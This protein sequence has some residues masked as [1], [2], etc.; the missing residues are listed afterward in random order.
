MI[1]AS[2]IDS[3]KAREL[4]RADPLRT[5]RDNFALS[6]D[7]IYLDG[8]S[9]GPLPHAALERMQRAMQRE[10]GDGLIAS[11]N[12][13][14][15]FTK[16]QRVGDRIGRLIGAADGQVV[17][18][19]S[20]SINLFKVLH[21]AFRARPQ[22]SRIV[23]EGGNFPT[24]LY[25]I[26]GICGLT[27]GRRVTL[28][29]EQQ[30]LADVLDEGVAAVVLTQVDFRTGLRH[31]MEAV[32]RRVHEAGA[33]MIWDLAHS[34]GAFPIALDACEV[35]YAV[36]CTYKYLNAGPGGPA[37][38]Y[39]A[40]RLQANAESPLTGWIG[41]ADPFSFSTEYEP[42]P[43]I[44][45]FLC[46]T[47]SILSFVPLEASLDIWESVSLDDVRRKSV[48]LTS[49]F[50]ELVDRFAGDHDLSLASPRDADSRGSQIS[51]RHEHGF[52]IVKA[53][54][55]DGVIG[56]FRAPDILRFGFTPLTLRYEDVLEAAR[57]LERIMQKK[58]WRDFLGERG[59]E[60]T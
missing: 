13:A 50:V 4:D 5:V 59:S 34:A 40:K 46:G 38:L 39:V 7:I 14:G 37:F 36:G 17:V 27:P 22:R 3:L 43:D 42:A 21:A 11:W 52:A 44:T 58:L 20:T 53:L 45:R 19:D 1:L 35:D 49:L 33:L 8:N 28:I 31:D 55:A 9:L 54:I 60:V 56:D 51:L 25:V 32:T 29:Q 15:W 57:R 41:H 10:W 47:P 23:T 30:P 24:D 16:P 6:P 48:A 18:A 2:D 26:Q 12:E